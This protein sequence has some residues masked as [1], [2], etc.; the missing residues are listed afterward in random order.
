MSI[1]FWPLVNTNDLQTLSDATKT[2][3]PKQMLPCGTRQ[4]LTSAKPGACSWVQPLMET[5]EVQLNAVNGYLNSDYAS[6]QWCNALAI[7]HTLI[8]VTK[9]IHASSQAD[10]MYVGM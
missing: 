10:V 5:P 9:S 4:G 8:S 3:E 7:T 2:R 6:F 1:S